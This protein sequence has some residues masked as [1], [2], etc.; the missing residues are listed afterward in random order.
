[1]TMDKIKDTIKAMDDI[2]DDNEAM[3]SN[4]SKE[5][6]NDIESHPAY[7]I[8]SYPLG[9]QNKEKVVFTRLRSCK[10]ILP[11]QHVVKKIHTMH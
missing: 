9:N 5:K 8:L 2:L 3:Y 7:F 6:S 4:E 10:S 1:M 11:F